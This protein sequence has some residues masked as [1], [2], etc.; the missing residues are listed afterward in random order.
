MVICVVECPRRYCISFMLMQLSVKD[1]GGDT[2]EQY[3]A[4]RG[5]VDRLD[6]AIRAAGKED[7]GQEKATAASEEAEAEAASA[8]ADGETRAEKTA[9]GEGNGRFSLRAFSDGKR[10][11]EVK[12]D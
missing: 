12:T 10:F 11:V 7:R 2:L 5:I 3:K 4:L 9:A 1:E 8:E 6:E